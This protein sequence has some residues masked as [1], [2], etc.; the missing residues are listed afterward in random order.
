MVSRLRSAQS[1]VGETRTQLAPE[2]GSGRAP[3]KASSLPRLGRVH[4]GFPLVYKTPC[5]C[6][7]SPGLF[8]CQRAFKN[9]LHGKQRIFTSVMR[10]RT[11]FNGRAEALTSGRRDGGAQD[12]AGSA[13]KEVDVLIDPQW[14]SEPTENPEVV[15]L[16]V[17]DRN[18]I[19]ALSLGTGIYLHALGQGGE[20]LKMT[21]RQDYSGSKMDWV[22]RHVK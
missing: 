15:G 1:F 8:Q 3:R 19:W 9:T 10:T 18:G 17:E 5:L 16:V 7:L 2:G 22:G 21:F 20:L 13:G 6:D 4:R 11:R 12:L 14:T